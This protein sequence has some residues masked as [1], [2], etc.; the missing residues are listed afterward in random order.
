MIASRLWILLLAFLAVAGVG[1]ALVTQG[2]VQRQFDERIADALRRD[3]F[4]LELVLKLD[5]RTRIDDSAKIAAQED[6]RTA[7]RTASARKD[8]TGLKDLNSK[9]KSK[10]LDL[11]HQLAGAAGDVIFALDANGIIIA[12]LG[13]NEAHFG[14]SLATYPLVERA[15]AGYVRDDVWLYDSNVYRMAARP[16]IDQGQYVGAVLLGKL[17]DEKLAKLMSDRLNGATV[18]FFR[19]DA[20]IA[21]SVPSD[22]PEAPS[23]SDIAAELQPTL[24]QQK[25]KLVAGDA[26]DPVSLREKA[27]AIYSLVVGEGAD[28]RI[29]YAIARP[30]TVIATAP[31]L[32]GLITSED[33]G[34]LNFPLLIVF[35]VMLFSMAMVFF[36]FERDWPTMRFRNASKMLAEHKMDRFDP[37]QFGSAYRAIASEMNTALDHAAATATPKSANLDSILGPAPG[38]PQPAA[39]FSFGEVPQPS[40]NAPPMN[41]LMPQQPSMPAPGGLP[42]SFAPGAGGQMPIL[43]QSI[44]PLVPS[45]APTMAMSAA[46]SFAQSGMP[47]GFPQSGAPSF[48][49]SAGPSY[50]QSSPPGPQSF[51][52]NPSYAQTVSLPPTPAASLTPGGLAPPSARPAPP[53]LP[54]RTPA[55]PP[56]QINSTP[57]E[58]DRS[59]YMP[60]ADYMSVPPS[61]SSMATMYGDETTVGASPLEGGFDERPAPQVTDGFSADHFLSV[62]NDFLRAK[63][64]CGE[65]TTGFTFEKFEQQLR[66][67]RAE[68]IS[69]HNSQDVRFSVYIKDGKAKL[70]ATPIKR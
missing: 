28:A 23:G 35:G 5:A 22:V 58:E 57:P 39:F 31:E 33:I 15:L 55:L 69:Q 27:S 47:G 32:F 11:N 19:N 53:P 60:I 49:E 40:L 30:R 56:V 68:I 21:T 25:E 46:P 7:L 9:L 2:V 3:R 12:Q 18:A 16:V 67:R 17:L 1:T 70:K 54:P 43:T 62:F 20:V 36:F 66:A 42:Q 29:G 4:E 63:E 34:R 8:D 45:R 65:P 24:K 14:G 50:A 6:V 59:S 61:P 51:G 41:S 48:P 64:E 13:S 38:G 44:V 52:P 37:T 26:T 10:L